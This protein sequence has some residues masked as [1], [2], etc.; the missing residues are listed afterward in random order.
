[1]SKDAALLQMHGGGLQRTAAMPERGGDAMTV[2]ELMKEL[3]KMPKN[4]EVY[5]CKDWEMLDED[6][7]LCDLYRL[8]D[9]CEQRIIID[10]GLDF[11]DID[12]VI[13][14]FDEERAK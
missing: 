2:Q 10:D 3:R 13:L 8:N 7:C 6:N 11:V 5:L 14:C 12:E 9:V 4:A 1:M